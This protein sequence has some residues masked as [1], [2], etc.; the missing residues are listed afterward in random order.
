[1]PTPLGYTGWKPA[2]VQAMLSWMSRSAPR[3]MINWP[4]VL[5]AILLIPIGLIAQ[6]LPFKKT[7]DRT[8]AEVARYLRDFINGTDGDWD[9][10]DFESIPI[11]DPV[12][13]D[14][15]RQAALVGP[16][17]SRAN[18][19]FDKLTVL[20]AKVEALEPA[21]QASFPRE[22]ASPGPTLKPDRSVTT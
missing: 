9:W 20:L 21:T 22:S 7:R 15:R 17:A 5:L 10:D 2:S 8:P 4:G 11:T 14:V 18:A 19:D 6:L 3:A 12:L 16:G 1:M 13:E